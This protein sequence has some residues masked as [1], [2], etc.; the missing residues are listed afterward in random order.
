MS[1]SKEKVDAATGEVVRMMYGRPYLKPVVMA[2]GDGRTKSEFAKSCDLKQ[3]IKVY[4]ERGVL[5]GMRPPP[6]PQN[7]VDLTAYPDSYHEALNLVARVGQHFANLPS[8]VRNKF[9]NDPQLYLAD[10]EARQKAAEE[11]S[12]IGAKAAREAVQYDIEDKLGRGRQKAEERAK[13]VKEAQKEP[14]VS[15]PKEG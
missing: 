13:R 2:V 9:H 1:K 8:E 4:Q 12:Q 3:R 11:A 14:P 5:P 7:D 10:L 6:G 15:P